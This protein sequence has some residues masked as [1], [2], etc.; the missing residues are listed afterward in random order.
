MNNYAV[1]EPTISNAKRG[2]IRNM[3]ISINETGKLHIWQRSANR[4]L[5]MT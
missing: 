2:M 5:I 1:L 4:Y 3:L